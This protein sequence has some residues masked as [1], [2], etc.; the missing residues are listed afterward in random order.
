MVLKS[1]GNGLTQMW[2]NKR[3]I[4]IFYLSNL[5]FGLVLML[6]FRASLADFVG[7]SLMGAELAGRFDMNFL[8]EFLKNNPSVLSIYQTLFFFVPTVYWL[9]SLFLSGGAFAQFASDASFSA[10]FFWGSAAKYFGRFLRLALLSL[11]VL[12]LL[13]SLQFIETGVERILFG[14]DPY[15]Y[16]TYWG[17]WIKFAL[18]ALAILL[19]SLI[20]DYARILTVVRDENKMRAAL[21]QGVRFAFG[22]L[23]QTFSLAFVL[24]LAG[25]LALAIYF[26]AAGTLSAPH[27]LVILTLFLLQQGYVFFRMAVRLTLYSSQM[28]LFRQVSGA[29][30]GAG[31]PVVADS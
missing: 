11:P 4:L 5:L 17:G 22:H 12:G 13:L 10:H 31:E 25:G 24:F 19:F 28:S 14:N 30:A 27:G 18:R 15:E 9:F 8:F 2:R 23:G 7:H 20:L 3:V 21:W 29:H 1:L 6:P 16:V 26:P